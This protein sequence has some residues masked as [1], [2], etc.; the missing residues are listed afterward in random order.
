MLTAGKFWGL[1]IVALRTAI[2]VSRIDR[3]RQTQLLPNVFKRMDIWAC[4]ALY[5]SGLHSGEQTG[6]C[7]ADPFRPI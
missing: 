4:P 6:T 2:I 1:V 5:R 7:F 3:P